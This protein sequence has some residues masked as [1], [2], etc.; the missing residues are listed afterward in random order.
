M[1]HRSAVTS[2]RCRAE[3]SLRRHED[4]ILRRF[5]KGLDIDPEAIQPELRLVTSGS[6][7]ELLFRYARLHWSIPVSAGYGRRLRF[8]VV[9]RQN[10]CLIGIIGL[11]DPVIRLGARDQ[12]VGWDR[13]SLHQ[14]LRHVMDAFVL[15]AVPP[16]NDLLCGKLVAMLAA[17]TE[18]R[19]AFKERY[20]G[21]ASLISGRPFNGELALITTLSAL[22]RSSMYN[23]LGL[24][25]GPRFISAGETLGS[26]E[27][28]FSNGVYAE[29][30]EYARQHGSPSAKNSAWGVGFRNRREVVRTALKLLDLN[31]DLM[32]HGVRRSVYCVP[33][34]S[35]TREFLRGEQ[36]TLDFW[37]RN[38]E[39]ITGW[40][41]DRWLLPRAARITRWRDFDPESLRLWP[42]EGERS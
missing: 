10:N 14:R 39:E 31:P 37:T 4:W 20:S 22:G 15:G 40:F 16:Y 38:A 26:G 27:F 18:V 13:D 42:S 19:T 2:S 34:A 1:L 32:Y 3:R 5:A 24:P 12:W 9:D 28:Q 23:R 17:S 21:S 29:L 7:D 25:G 6:S 36:D 30:L 41:R 8:L 35:N 33:L 11:G